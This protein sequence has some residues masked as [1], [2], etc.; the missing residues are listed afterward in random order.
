MLIEAVE[1]RTRTVKSEHGECPRGL[2]VEHVMPRAWR[3]YWGGDIYSE[4]EA[5][6]R[7]TLIHTLGN[8]TLVNSKLNPAM[9]NRPWTDAEALSCGLGKTGKRSELLKHSTLKVNADLIAG[10][11]DR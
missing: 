9:S 8:L 11:P 10:A 4:G 1:D 7:D 2:T 3:E 6:E 5:M